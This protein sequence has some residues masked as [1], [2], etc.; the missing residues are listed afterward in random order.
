[1]ALGA[2]AHQDL[3]FER[4]VEELER[5]R[6]LSR[7]PLFQVSFATTGTPWH[8]F[9]I[10]G[11][12]LGFFDVKTPVELYD[13]TLQ[14]FEAPHGLQAVFSYNTDLFDAATVARMGGHL[15]ILLD[16]LTG[17][18]QQPVDAISLL[19]EDERRQLLESRPA[20]APAP[21]PLI[22]ELFAQQAARQP[23]APALLWDGGELSYEELD[24]RANRLA[25]HLGTLGAGPEVRVALCLD[26]TADFAVALLAVWKAGA[27]ALPLDTGAPAERLRWLLA[28]SGARMLVTRS[29]LSDLQDQTDP[30]IVRLDADRA[31]FARH[32]PDAVPSKT[33][34]TQAAYLLYTSGS[35]GA[36]KGVLVPHEALASHCR[37]MARRLALGPDDRVLQT[38]GL[39]FDVAL[40]EMVTA[41]ISGA[42]VVPWDTQRGPAELSRVLARDGIT[43]ANLPTP[44]WHQAV[45]EWA[46]GR[47][48]V[49][50]PHLRWMIIGSE[51]APADALAL[52]R[53]TPL[54]RLGTTTLANAYG[55]TETTITA[56]FHVADLDGGAD[57]FRLAI[58]RPLPDRF[59][60]LLDV[61]S[62]LGE[63]VPAGVPGEICIGGPAL[64]RGY[65]G[66]PDL[67]AAAFVPDPWS[68][69]PGAR[70][71]RTGDLARRR[72]EGTLAGALEY[73]GRRDRQLKL[74]GY[75]IEPG[76]VEAVLL[77]HSGVQAAAVGIV[78]G[79]G[80]AE[81]RALTAW[82]VPSGG[83]VSL[84]DGLREHLRGR[85][86]AWMIPSAFVEI[87]VLPLTAGGK[88]DRASLPRHAS[89]AVAPA[90]SSEPVPDALDVLVADLWKEA[91]GLAAHET[92]RPDDNFFDLG[93]HSMLL[94]WV[95]AKLKERLGA[96]LSMIDLFNAPT[97]RALAASLRPK[98]EAAPHPQ[99]LSRIEGDI[100]II[101]MAG[102]FPG[103][104]DVDALWRN[105]RD[106]VESITFFDPEGKAWQP[107]G[108]SVFHV[109]A[110]GVLEGGADG[111]DAAFFGYGAREAEVMDPQ[112][113]LFLE[114][115]WQAMEN[116]GY[117]A[118]Q[119]SGG[120]VGVFGGASRT[121]YLALLVASGAFSDLA[122]SQLAGLGTEIDFLTTRVSYKLNLEGPSFDVQAACATSLV[123]VHL[124]CQSLLAGD[125]ALALAG[126]VAV[127][128]QPGS[129]YLYQEGGLFS[130]DG[131]CR[132]FDARGQ[133]SVDADGVAIV[134]LKRLA[135]A[136]ADGDPVHAVI[137][138]TA[139]N[140]DGSEKVGFLAPRQAS[141]SKL[142]RSTL[143]RA[144]IS[145]DTIGL[146]E[147]HGNGTLLGDS[148]EVGAL[149]EAFRADTGRTA[150]CALGSI[151][152]NLGYLHG[153]AG[154]AGLIKA[155]LA[156]ENRTI[157]PSLHCEQPNPDLRLESS[158]FF[159]PRQAIPW[160]APDGHPRR[161]AVSAFGAG[162]T[163][164]HVVLEEA[165]VVG[166]DIENGDGWHLLVVSA[167]TATATERAATEL[168]NHLERHPGLPLADVA[169]TLQVGR[170]MF[171][172]RRAVLCRDH[173]EAVA[174]LRAAGDPAARR[175][176]PA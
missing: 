91:L 131:H 20:A 83:T 56:T 72:D 108:G 122:G 118:G 176:E 90:V 97:V 174:G 103:A 42:A 141:Q 74:R 147:A 59:A 117:A 132:S 52:W 112:H 46:S 157:P 48:P 64:A 152:T 86:P 158:P 3:P 45:R 127:S 151:K 143:E 33:L 129:G 172:H 154:I 116:A 134:V 9:D 119:G 88:V 71:Y 27:A 40:E 93:G 68:P 164:A 5:A 80:T 15:E 2:Y 114:T 105:L 96:D 89:P 55:A 77:Q 7:H 128:G 110:R 24:R 54:A 109:P 167:R 4:L 62:D 123:A 168:A 163:K 102:R 29:G 115:A 155:V 84:R 67:T 133:G 58:G 92:V 125:C 47:T 51:A 36:P 73:L 161:A 135:D 43:V 23:A 166:K 22:T 140:N 12:D 13:I 81:T 31:T 94:S 28:D 171:E 145:A 78:E 50:A 11:L 137:K 148:I 124:A 104:R 14:T 8:A 32:S 113:R 160:E 38:A 25:R 146:V 21:P 53:Q 162:G 17:D 6:D 30:P 107:P 49:A 35:T 41:W 19:R 153:A 18:P 173:A 139:V 121:D 106:G 63:P 87:P 82:I 101:G 16:A 144:G 98:L 79:D 66:R 149:T 1:M 95:R 169:F 175:G 76:E 156:L 165:P 142:V 120:P 111:W 136:L 10:P 150:F 37:E 99:P 39:V 170:R 130:P 126:G 65:M 61:L 44:L 85:L 69:Q 57:L 100:A 138:A 75:R 26:R 34:P 60:V 159:V 70:L